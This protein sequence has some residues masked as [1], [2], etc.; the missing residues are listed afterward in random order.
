MDLIIKKATF[1]DIEGI[2]NNRMDF[3]YQ[4]TGKQPTEEFKA[5]TKDYLYDHINDD[6]LFCYIASYNGKMVSSVIICIYNVIPKPSNISGKIGY[7][8]NVYT[9][10]EFRR[11][12]LATSLMKAA[13]EEAGKLGIGEIYLSA[14][15]DGKG[16]Y[17]K[18]QFQYLGEEMCLRLI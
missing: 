14:T 2:F 6:S 17:E 3:L 18:L 1:E 4:V 7:V 5:A 15:D 8:F 11:Q 13:I 10:Q 16:I 12:G 9:L